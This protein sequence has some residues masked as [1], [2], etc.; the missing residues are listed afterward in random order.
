[1][2]GPSVS[3]SV[4]PSAFTPASASAAMPLSNP[5]VYF[6]AGSIRDLIV[7]TLGIS[8]HLI[9][10]KK[11][12]DVRV[13]YAKYLAIV[14]TL[15][16][17]SQLSANGTW[18][19]DNTNDDV[20]EVFV[21]KSVYFRN[22]SKIFPLLV[23]YPAMQEWLEKTPE[24]VEADSTDA[25]RAAADAVVWGSE[26]HT[27][28]GLRKILTAHEKASAVKGKGKGKGN[29]K[30]K[31]K[32]KEVNRDGSSSPPIPV[33]KTANKKDKRKE[34]IYNKKASSSKGHHGHD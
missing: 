29:G 14:D 31:G 2:S 21:S 17:L 18:K 15:E 25:E 30:G 33:K 23:Y 26:K 3:G 1:L 13:A 4:V 22:H 11:G 8:E 19:H 7:T 34:V 24:T 32:G 20:V 9:N 16:K 5:P 28:D 6:A 27:L 10:R 12:A